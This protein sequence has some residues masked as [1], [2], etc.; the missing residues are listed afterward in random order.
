MRVA[1]IHDWLT[2][3]RG[4]EKV[5]EMLC[6]LFPDAPLWTLLHV[7]GSVCGAIEER[8][9]H[10]S[11]LQWMPG[12]AKRY[13]NYLP[14]FPLFAEL[15]KVHDA[16]L[17]ISTS[18]AVAKAMVGRRQGS[19]PYHIC[20]IHTPMRY[21]WDMFDA[22]FGPDQVGWLASNLAYRPII[23]GLRKYD[24][25]TVNRVDL[26]IANSTFVADRVYRIYGK[27]SEVIPPPV[28][29]DR[30]AKQMREPEEWYLVVSALVPYKR[31]EDAICAC[32]RAGR[33]L[34]IVGSGPELKS[35]QQLSD[36]VGAQVEFIGYC[37]DT[38]LPGY[39]RRARGLL[40]P[41]VE[42][43]GIVPVEA[44][45]SGC[46]V[47]GLAVG[48]LLD[49]M[50][51]ETAVFYSD[52]SAEGLYRAIREFEEKE[53]TFSTDV[54]RRRASEFSQDQFLARIGVLISLYASAP[55]PALAPCPLKVANAKL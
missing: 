44:I 11:L 4:G 29:V 25:H 34:K 37:S 35:L 41:G 55:E 23:W 12:A 1:L 39:Y 13:R 50:T 47:I 54:L 20:Y 33:R 38:D 53:A 22:Y 43:F 36:T 19:R 42:D 51:N 26:Y 9:I 3:M 31:V 46:P 15:N 32:R 18:H 14:L 2:G 21:A 28:N 30:F 8:S 16:D 6:R 17:I 40:F 7:R 48:G 10:T 27:S 49:S 5:L 45:A 52:A 24:R